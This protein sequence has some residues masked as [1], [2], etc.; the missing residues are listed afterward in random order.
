MAI[1]NLLVDFQE[2]PRSVGEKSI[3][4]FKQSRYGDARIEEGVRG[5]PVSRRRSMGQPQLAN[6]CQRLS[7][8]AGY[9]ELPVNLLM[10]KKENVFIAQFD[11]LTMA[12][13][14]SRRPNASA[15]DLPSLDRSGSSGSQVDSEDHALTFPLTA[16][17]RDPPVVLKL[18]AIQDIKKWLQHRLTLVV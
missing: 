10:R 18:I 6:H 1:E 7:R 11:T 4:R 3:A 9:E 17:D 14:Y 12:V 5:N 13:V 16:L 15:D 8:C 2:E